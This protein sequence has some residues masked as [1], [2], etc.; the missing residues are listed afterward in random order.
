[1]RLMSIEYCRAD[2]ETMQHRLS[3]LQEEASDSLVA[4]W[5][6]YR[7]PVNREGFC[8]IVFFAPLV[9]WSN[10]AIYNQDRL[11]RNGRRNGIHL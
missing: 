3:L 6:K 8:L 1:M 2:L 10:T 7:E 4:T 9:A 11:L 5:L